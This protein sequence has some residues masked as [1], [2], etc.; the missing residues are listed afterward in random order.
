MS[1][2]FRP[3]IYPRQFNQLVLAGHSQS[4]Y[5][6]NVDI[7]NE[8]DDLMDKI[9]G[10]EAKLE[11]TTLALKDIKRSGYTF[12]ERNQVIDQAMRKLK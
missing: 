6:I 8:K 5:L 3:F 7:N 11:I 10:L 9:K 1:D 12:L 4:D 2:K